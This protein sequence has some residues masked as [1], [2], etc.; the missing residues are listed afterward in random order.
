MF[1]SLSRDAVGCACSPFFGLLLQRAAVPS[2]QCNAALSHER[3]VA[4]RFR[5]NKMRFA[6]LK[7]FF[8]HF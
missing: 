6:F 2:L 7:I 1:R 5:K 3:S 8:F 4:C